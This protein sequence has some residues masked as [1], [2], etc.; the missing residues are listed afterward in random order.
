MTARATTTA[1]MHP[2]AA[3]VPMRVRNGGFIT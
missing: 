3:A 2:I 1:A